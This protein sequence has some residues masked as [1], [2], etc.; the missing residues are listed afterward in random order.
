MDPPGT[1]LEGGGAGDQITGGQA[2]MAETVK[3]LVLMVLLA[4][5]E[6]PATVAGSDSSGPRKRL[7]L[8]IA[9]E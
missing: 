4:F 8:I 5:I 6:G 2:R 1:S 9:I 7:R 3:P